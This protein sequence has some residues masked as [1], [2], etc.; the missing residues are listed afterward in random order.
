M[1]MC[2]WSKDPAIRPGSR[3]TGENVERSKLWRQFVRNI[4]LGALLS[5]FISHGVN[6]Q[7]KILP[8]DPFSRMDAASIG[9]NL[10]AVSSLH[11]DTASTVGDNG[12]VRIT[13]DWGYHWSDTENIDGES[14]VLLGVDMVDSVNTYAVGDQGT[15]LHTSDA[16]VTWSR[17]APD[18][19]QILFGVW[20]SSSAT[21]TAVG[22]HGLILRTTDGGQN[23]YKSREDSTKY[24]PLLGVCFVNVDTGTVVGGSGSILRTTDAGNTWET[25]TS[26]VTNFL[27]A[28]SFSSPTHGT[29]VGTRGVIL[30]TTDGGSTWEKQTTVIDTAAHQTSDST[31]YYYGVSFK[32]DST[33]IIVGSE[34]RIILTT[35]GGTTW[36]V[37]GS[38]TTNNLYSVAF[39][40]TNKWMAVGGYGA[41]VQRVDTGYVVTSVL[42][43]RNLIPLASLLGQNY[44]N[45]FNPSTVI[46]FSLSSQADVSLDIY[47]L[48]GRKVSTLLNTTLPAGNH[49]VEWQPAQLAS[50]VYFYR[51]ELRSKGSRDHIV[52]TRKLLLLR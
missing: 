38:T 15:I 6:A 4:F 8:E 44:P 36:V 1:A 51:L 31:H 40:D 41:I 16:G 35:D 30:H 37:Q 32:D 17:T 7:N 21:G 46:P 29:V 34:G 52:Q 28:V 18:S 45:P 23:W 25:E 9:T 19:T 5:L 22:D 10:W 3:K 39:R 26:G 43:R 24:P 42:P 13:H 33:G 27:Y 11:V 20:F 49:A 47:D 48:L 50:G 2:R 12:R 14:T